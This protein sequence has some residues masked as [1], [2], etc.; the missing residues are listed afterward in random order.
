MSFSRLKVVFA[1]G[2]V[3]SAVAIPGYAQSDA[4]LADRIQ[5]GD[6]NVALELI[7]EGADVNQAQPDGT[8]PIHW[9]VYRVDRELVAALLE[10]GA[11]ADVVN[12][13]GASPL[14]EAVKVADADLVEML[15][16][17]GADANVAN[18]DGQTPL[19][20]AARTGAV[21]VARLLVRHGADVN[22]RE[23]FREQTALMWA[24][25]QDHAGMVRF[26]ISE[27]AALDVRAVA[28]DWP[29]QMTS[30]PR[31]QYRPTGGLTPLLYAARTGCGGCVSA[32]LDAGADVN[33][34]NPD[35]MTPLMMAIDNSNFEVALDLLER[36]ANP[37]VWD[38]W[39]RTALYVAVTMRGGPDGHD[40]PRPPASLA[41]ITLAFSASS[42]WWPR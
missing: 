38:W 20:L 10:G 6:R 22:A 24:A 35:G 40:G 3:F 18:D 17:A 37:H 2:F 4:S 19:M 30:E 33:L 28:N 8:G 39:G 29:N 23:Q 21:D 7:A 12:N 26:L 14:A 42:I 31:V 41:L 36:G 5:A 11:R 34:P 16:D 13:Y 25:A 32:M 15:L 27:G 9:A 1:V